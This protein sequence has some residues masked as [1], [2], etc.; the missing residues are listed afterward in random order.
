MS[1]HLLLTNCNWTN[2]INTRLW[3]TINLTHIV[4]MFVIVFDVN[5]TW[6]YWCVYKCVIVKL[7]AINKTIHCVCVSACSI[8]IKIYLTYVQRSTWVLLLFTLW[9]VKSFGTI[10]QKCKLALLIQIKNLPWVPPCVCII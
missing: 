9:S 1:F 5:W 2:P 6:L 10:V 3:T 4:T 7:N 8:I